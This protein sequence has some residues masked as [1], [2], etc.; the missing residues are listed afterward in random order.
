M[1]VGENLTHRVGRLICRDAADTPISPY[2]QNGSKLTKW[3]LF[4]AQNLL[5][6]CFYT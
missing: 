5:Y 2:I 3:K 4:R 1:Y 6:M